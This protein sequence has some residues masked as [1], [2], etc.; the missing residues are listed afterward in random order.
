MSLSDDTIGALDTGTAPVPARKLGL[1]LLIIATAQLMLVLDDTIV[2]IALPTIQ[3]SLH[4][5]ASSLN[6]AISFYALA[7]GGLLLV[8]GRAGDL[9]GRLRVFRAGLIVFTLASV[10]GGL[11]VN[12]TMLVT[13]RVVQGCGAA[14]A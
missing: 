7:F 1:A 12:E 8:G 9:F 5:P 13:A 10:T 14:L 11:A 3:R 6:W 2:N 4:V